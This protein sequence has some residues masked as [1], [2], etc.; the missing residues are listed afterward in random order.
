MW[1]NKYICLYISWVLLSISTY[2]VINSNQGIRKHIH[3]QIFVWNECTLIFIF[4]IHALLSKQIKGKWDVYNRKRNW[5]LITVSLLFSFYRD[6]VKLIKHSSSDNLN[7]WMKY[8]FLNVLKFLIVRILAFWICLAYFIPNW[9]WN[10]L[11]L[12][13]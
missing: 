4:N 13:K 6:I 2:T 5:T 1:I 3:K 8:M 10:A 11:Y 12:N 9:L 7:L